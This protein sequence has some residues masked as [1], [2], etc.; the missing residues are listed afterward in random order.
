MPKD[1]AYW[2]RTTKSAQQK[3]EEHGLASETLT[4]TYILVTVTC[5]SLFGGVKLDGRGRVR[6]WVCF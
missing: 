4:G 5:S 2:H 6:S 1:S 3:A